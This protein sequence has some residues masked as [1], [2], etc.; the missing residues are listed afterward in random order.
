[1]SDAVSLKRQGS[2]LQKF[3]HK[4]RKAHISK[5]AFVWM[6]RDVNVDETGLFIIL[7][8]P[9][10]SDGDLSIKE[11]FRQSAKYTGFPLLKRPWRNQYFAWKYEGQHKTPADYIAAM[12]PTKLF[13][14]GGDTICTLIDG[15]EKA[16]DFMY[17]DAQILEL[18]RDQSN[19]YGGKAHG[20][21]FADEGHMTLEAVADAAADADIAL[22]N[23]D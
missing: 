8:K 5:Q 10:A 9:D 20:T 15:G 11:Y 18:V 4:K 21:Y 19:V 1:M 16:M 14:Q 6:L 2:L 7:N 23:A 22:A 3:V 17:M 12:R 13:T